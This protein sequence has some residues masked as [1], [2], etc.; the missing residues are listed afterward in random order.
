M[1]IY[2][3][4]SDANFIA[5]LGSYLEMNLKNVDIKQINT[6][7]QCGKLMID[8]DDVAILSVSKGSV[9]EGLPWKNITRKFS[10]SK[11]MCLLSNDSKENHELAIVKNGHFTMHKPLNCEILLHNLKNFVLRI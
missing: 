2:L 4:D 7:E 6:S 10:N 5:I 8:H 11:V 3:I 9:F 1:K